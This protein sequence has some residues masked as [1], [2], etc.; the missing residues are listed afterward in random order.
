V[1]VPVVVVLAGPD[2]AWA[3]LLPFADVVVTA[4]TA[5]GELFAR[6]PGLALVLVPGHTGYTIHGRDGTRRWRAGPIG[7]HTAA[8]RDAHAAW[9]AGQGAAVSRPS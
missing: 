2:D 9:L 3:P 6:L 8:A 1:V 7:E 4:G 5:A